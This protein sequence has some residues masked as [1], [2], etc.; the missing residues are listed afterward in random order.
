[1]TLLNFKLWMVC[2]ITLVTANMC[3]ADEI[4]HF[5]C[6][7]FWVPFQK[8]C[9]RIFGTKLNWAAAEARCNQHFNGYDMGHLVS[10]RNEAENKFVS[11]LWDSSTG[12]LAAKSD[13]TFWIGLTDAGD[14]GQWVW[15][16]NN[17]LA[18]Y[19]SW[20]KNQPNNYN[21]EDCAHQWKRDPNLGT[22]NDY[23]CTAGLF[24]VCELPQNK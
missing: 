6:P 3:V 10:L 16:D 4:R 11:R 7:A 12:G 17:Q 9:Y 22:W 2:C 18:T 21:N 5:A 8:S 13:Y 14:E 19:T 24:Y 23:P 15:T 20:H 1:M